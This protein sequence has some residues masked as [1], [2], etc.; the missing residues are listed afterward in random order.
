MTAIEPSN[1]QASTVAAN[2]EPGVLGLPT[3]AELVRS[4]L[5]RYQ[6]GP[7]AFV[8]IPAVRPPDPVMAKRHEASDTWLAG[9]R[10]HL[11]SLLGSARTARS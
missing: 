10:T 8:N 4:N 9:A 7:D 1:T 6:R 11:L 5:L 2:S 3:F